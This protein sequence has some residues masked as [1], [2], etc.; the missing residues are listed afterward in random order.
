MEADAFL[1]KSDKKFERAA[2]CRPT[3]CSIERTRTLLAQWLLQ[4]LQRALQIQLDVAFEEHDDLP[5]MAE[6]I[7]FFLLSYPG[8]LLAKENSMKT[9]L[10]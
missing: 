6:L 1:Q 5:A 9:E 4:R 3:D 8:K 2:M 7:I 10:K